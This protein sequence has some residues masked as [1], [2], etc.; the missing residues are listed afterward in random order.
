MINYSNET[1]I[2]NLLTS[3]LNLQE[4]ESK[5]HINFKFLKHRFSVYNKIF[6]L[7]IDDS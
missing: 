4:D 5:N 6:R 7:L 1:A 2:N 3:F